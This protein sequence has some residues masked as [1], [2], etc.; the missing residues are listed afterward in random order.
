MAEWQTHKFQELAE[1]TLRGGS[2]PL[3]GTSKEFASDLGSPR[4]AR[5]LNCK[6]FWAKKSV[7]GFVP[8]KENFYYLKF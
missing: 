8:G 7:D 1:I 4:F 5:R 2:T 3:L 6:E